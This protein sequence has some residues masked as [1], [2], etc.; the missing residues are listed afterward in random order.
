MKRLVFIIH[1]LELFKQYE[2]ICRTLTLEGNFEITC[3]I[4][5]RNYTATQGAENWNLSP[6]IKSALLETFDGNVITLSGKEFNE[7]S[8]MKKLNP[9]CL[10]R[11][12]PWDHHLPPLVNSL[13][14]L[15]SKL[16]Y[17]PYNSLDLYFEGAQQYNQPFHNICDKIFV[18]NQYE[19]EKFSRLRDM[20][21]D[22]VIVTGSP[23]IE[24][25]LD[26]SDNSKWPIDTPPSVKKVIWSPHH[27]F[28]PKWIGAST[29][30][31]NKE[32]FLRFA[33]EK[34]ISIVL[35]PHP[36]LFDKLIAR[37]IMSKSDLDEYL[38]KFSDDTYSDVDLSTDYANLF[39]SS[40]FMVTDGIS[41]LY[42]YITKNKPLIRTK[43]HQVKKF[44][45]MGQ[46]LEG[47][48]RTVSGS[49]DLADVLDS[50]VNGSY[51]DEEASERKRYLDVIRSDHKGSTERI[52]QIINREFL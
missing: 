11:Q 14:F 34:N 4:V 19:F 38:R 23:R 20:G 17:V 13:T 6:N 7:I 41:F 26:F 52:V 22:G 33:V 1:S 50:L 35:R 40:D 42:E 39:E 48:Y 37:N 49:A 43:N 44:N 5:P 24:S 46:Q 15:Y 36:Q 9:I 51:I 12:G 25:L 10:F 8:V 16:F 18:A 32:I 28:D 2:S 3:V 27:C 47:T 31:E 30:M 29:F 45:E 21:G